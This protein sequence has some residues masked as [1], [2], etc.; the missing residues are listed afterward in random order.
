MELPIHPC[1]ELPNLPLR[2][3]RHSLISHKA[4]FYPI[5][6]SGTSASANSSSQFLY[7]YIPAFSYSAL[8]PVVITAL[9][10]HRIFARY[11]LQ[12]LSSNT[13]GSGALRYLQG[14]KFLAP[15]LD[16]SNTAFKLNP[17]A[18]PENN[19]STCDGF[20]EISTH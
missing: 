2:H 14:P 15:R 16:C 11:N 1:A 13:N 10:P 8:R 17:S 19:R 5:S 20:W 9:L 6:I 12:H 7:Y 18:V 4:P 3:L